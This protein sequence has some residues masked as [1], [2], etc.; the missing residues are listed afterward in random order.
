METF[1]G[2]WACPNGYHLLGELRRRHRNSILNRFLLKTSLHVLLTFIYFCYVFD[3]LTCLLL[4][5]VSLD[6]DPVLFIL[7]LHMKYTV[8]VV[9]LHTY[10]VRFVIV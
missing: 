2:H 4:L 1:K 8:E 6:I 10:M 3:T 7:D 5:L 9:P